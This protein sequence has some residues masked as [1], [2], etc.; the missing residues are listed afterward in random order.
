MNSIQGYGYYCGEQVTILDS[1]GSQLLIVSSHNPIET[2]W[3]NYNDIDNTTWVISG[4]Q[5]A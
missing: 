2:Q 1:Y 3:V 5:V 4:T